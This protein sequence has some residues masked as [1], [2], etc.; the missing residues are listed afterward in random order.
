[1]P[2]ERRQLARIAVSSSVKRIT[3]RRGSL[4]K[5]SSSGL[6]ARRSRSRSDVG[7]L[8]AAE[9]VDTRGIV[10]AVHARMDL[11]HHAVV[12][13]HPRHL[14]QHVPRKQSARRRASAGERLA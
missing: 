7:A 6:S 12:E 2:G 3:D 13:A 9:A 10:V 8:V 4:P 11:Q 1:M 5:R 14:D